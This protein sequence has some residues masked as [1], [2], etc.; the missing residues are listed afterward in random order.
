MSRIPRDEEREKRI[1]FDVVV[2]AYDDVERAMGWFY[3]LAEQCDFPFKARCIAERSISP[4]LV[5][6]EVEV[7]S[8]ASAKECERELFVEVQWKDRQMAVPLSQLSIIE[9]SNTS[10]QIVEDWQY[11]VQRG[12]EF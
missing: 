5:D 1:D 3:Y 4:L 2:D 6:E 10:K 7:I 8:E 11:W 12:Y 9:S